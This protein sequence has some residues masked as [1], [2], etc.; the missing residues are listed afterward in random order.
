MNQREWAAVD[1]FYADQLG[2]D[3]PVLTAA[4]H[5][6]AAAGLP[7]INVAPNQGRLLS[8][9]ARSIGARRVLEIG[10]LCGYST[11][12][13]ASAL[14]ADG[15]LITLEAEPRHAEVARANLAAAGYAEL[16]DVRV[17]PA[18]DALPKL[19]AEGLGPFDLCFIDADKIN[20]AEY[21]RWAVELSHPGSMIIVDN[22]VRQGQVLDATSAAPAVVGT[23]RLAE[24][25]GAEPRVTAT[26]LQTVGAKG[27][28]GFILAVV[29]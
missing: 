8:L 20:N 14:P 1:A 25:I 28:D 22:V 21:F 15:E 7:G 6:S 18:I 3:A 19:A 10:T 29:N 16:V 24:L 13:L 9:L 26:A 23:R 5:A 27:W 12:W 4:L 17:G 2:Q 11:I